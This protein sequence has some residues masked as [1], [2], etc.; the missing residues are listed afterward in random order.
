MS[1]PID[2]RPVRFL[3]I[4]WLALMIALRPALA[5]EEQ[6]VA[7]RSVEF[8]GYEYM[9]GAYTGLLEAKNG[10]VYVGLCTH[11]GRNHAVLAVYDPA[12][13]KTRPVADMG[14]AAGE[15]GKGRLPQGKIHSRIRQAADGN[16]Y[17]TTHF[18]YPSNNVNAKID[19]PGGHFM[20]YNPGDGICRSIARAPEQEGIISAELDDA[21]QVMY[22]LTYPSGL[23]L[24]CDLKT[25]KLRNVGSLSGGATVCRIIACDDA[26]N[27]Y[28]SREP[29]QIVKY[30][31]RTKKIATLKTTVP[32]LDLNAPEWMGNTVGRKIWR[33]I[34]WDDKV[35][36]LYGIHGGTSRLFV[37]D[38]AAET[39]Q[40]IGQ[41]CA[42][43]DIG[44]EVLTYATLAFAQG[45]DRILYY[46]PSQ[47]LFD[48][49]N[50]K[51]L[52]GPAHLVTFNPSAITIRDHGVII[53][54]GQR[55]VLGCQ[56]AAVSRDGKTLYLMGAVEALAGDRTV[57]FTTLPVVKTGSVSDTGKIPYQIRLILLDI[58]HLKAAHV[59]HAIV[60][61]PKRSES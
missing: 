51:P 37:F 34:I 11:N 5:G 33:T 10:L 6:I 45:P 56:N 30:D 19:Y 60:S 50:S 3:S 1:A 8:P 55:R 21:H 27:V 29:D 58:D 32:S 47:G 43:S 20:V 17:F 25:G 14:Q 52:R 12:T 57:P 35:K 59:E 53:A 36:K 31:P 15:E 22:G 7:A 41:V 39:A 48:Y 13:G 16:I 4:A 46:A 24:I 61:A 23:F 40:G 2:W 42:Q 28:A 44:H 18:G 49:F 54:D 26:G 38:P 9:D